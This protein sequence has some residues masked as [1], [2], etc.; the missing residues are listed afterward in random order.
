MDDLR[1][2]CRDQADAGRLPLQQSR[3]QCKT[4]HGVRRLRL[5]ADI[6]HGRAD[7]LLR[8]FRAADAFVLWGSNMAEMHPILWTRLADRRLGHEH[9][10]RGTVDFH[11]SQHGLADMPIIFKPGTDLAILNY[12]AHHIITTG[13]VNEE[14]VS[15]HTTFMRGVTDIG[16]GLGPKIRSKKAATAEPTGKMEPIG[17]E[18]F[19]A[20][21]SD[22]TLEKTAE[23]TGV[24]PG[25]LEELA[26]LYAARVARS[27]RCGPWGSTSMSA[28]SG[29]TRWSTISIC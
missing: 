13:R 27:C 19:K 8:R 10:V 26:E 6:R 25:F 9:A 29:P 11:P 14:F 20:F 18:E 28:A 7:G 4:L 24:E 5:H 16:Y 2:L 21:V 17:F 12:I 15:E 1:R 22:Y 3:S 23:L